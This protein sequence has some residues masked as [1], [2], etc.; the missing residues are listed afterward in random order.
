MISGCSG[1]ESEH[2]VIDKLLNY[3]EVPNNQNDY[4]LSEDITRWLTSS[5]NGIKYDQNLIF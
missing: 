3:C 1:D 5:N 2:S 4:V